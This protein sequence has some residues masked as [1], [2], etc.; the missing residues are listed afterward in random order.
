MISITSAA[1]RLAVQCL[2]SAMVILIT[3][4]CVKDDLLQV[5][6]RSLQLGARQQ[7][8]CRLDRVLQPPAS[9]P[10]FGDEDA[11]D[12]VSINSLIGTARLSPWQAQGGCH[13]NGFSIVAGRV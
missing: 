5:F 4:S 12:G 8:D 10:S 9:A 7:G 13:G 1:L 2:I 11:S 6:S 3:C